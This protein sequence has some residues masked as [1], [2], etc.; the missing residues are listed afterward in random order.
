MV[1]YLDSS[2]AQ[3]GP[4]MHASIIIEWVL[5]FTALLIQLYAERALQCKLKAPS[6]S[7]KLRKPVKLKLLS[8]AIWFVITVSITIF[9]TPPWF[10]KKNLLGSWHN[11]NKEYLQTG[12]EFWC[13][14][15]FGNC[16]IVI[17]SKYSSC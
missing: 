5:L 1:S 10:M 16:V 6:E 7:V 17:I 11:N 13:L 2:G 9:L 12:P 4:L 14:V 15:I 8:L 3:K